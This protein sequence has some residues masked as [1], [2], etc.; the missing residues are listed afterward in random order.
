MSPSWALVTSAVQSATKTFALGTLVLQLAHISSHC[1]EPPTLTD[2]N[3]SK[4][5]VHTREERILSYSITQQDSEFK[6]HH[7]ML[8]TDVAE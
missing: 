7:S 3:T 5:T 8:L 4:E 6:A 1:Q 2:H